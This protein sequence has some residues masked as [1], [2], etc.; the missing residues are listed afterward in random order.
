[1][2][3]TW[4]N[5]NMTLLKGYYYSPNSLNTLLVK[6]NELLLFVEKDWFN[7]LGNSAEKL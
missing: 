4:I 3:W 1:M 6:I 7:I 2:D 5:G